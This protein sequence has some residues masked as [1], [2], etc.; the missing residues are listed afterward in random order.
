[1]G[2]QSLVAAHGHHHIAHISQSL[3]LM[4]LNTLVLGDLECL[5]HSYGAKPHASRVMS[6]RTL[7][8]LV[9]LQWNGLCPSLLTFCYLV[10]PA[11]AHD[12]EVAKGDGCCSPMVAWQE[13]DLFNL[14]F[15]EANTHLCISLSHIVSNQ[16]I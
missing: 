8:C 6:S 5:Q 2:D 13:A 15:I 11:E 3:C 12:H 4:S 1:M 14:V 16:L 7:V 9:G 10:A